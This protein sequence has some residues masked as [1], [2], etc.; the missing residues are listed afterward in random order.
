MFLFFQKSYMCL[1]I[2]FTHSIV[3]FIK[4]GDDFWKDGIIIFYFVL[5][6]VNSVDGHLIWVFRHRIYFSVFVIILDPFSISKSK[7]G[8]AFLVCQKSVFL[9]ILYVSSFYY[10]FLSIYHQILFLLFVY[11][12]NPFMKN[13]NNMMLNFFISYLFLSY[14]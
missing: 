9:M 10:N 5:S 2:D 3:S 4:I 6:F 8:S 11:F 14:I 7:I 13:N 12:D 1:L